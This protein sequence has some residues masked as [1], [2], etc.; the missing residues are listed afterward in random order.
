[1]A[2]EFAAEGAAA[3]DPYPIPLERGDPAIADWGPLI[4]SVLAD[5]RTGVSTGEISAR[6]HESVAAL[7][8]DVAVRVRAPRVA[9]A[10]GCF[11][12]ARLLLRVKERLTRR[13]FDV[14]TPRAFPPN[15]GGISL[16]QVL[17]ASRRFF[18]R[19]AP[20]A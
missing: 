1:M 8:E 17:V 5:R 14:Y 3:I 9:L 19:R 13:G 6:F 10:G 2:L 12:N 4:E 18:E 16:G 11:Q 7:A 15:D 20:C